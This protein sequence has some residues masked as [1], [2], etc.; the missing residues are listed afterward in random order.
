MH[1][2]LER[3]RVGILDRQL[4]WLGEARRVPA[5]YAS[6]VEVLQ[7]AVV[8]AAV[9]EGSLDCIPGGDVGAALDADAGRP[10]VV[11][12]AERLRQRLRRLRGIVVREEAVR[13]G[14]VVGLR[15]HERGV[16]DLG[17]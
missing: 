7:L 3:D 8:V 5:L 14:V 9:V 1:G 16:A 15:L 4:V 2:V 17:V 12:A 10:I 6:H 13:E 11:V